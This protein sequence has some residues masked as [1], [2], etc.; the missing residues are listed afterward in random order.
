MRV[1]YLLHRFRKDIRKRRGKLAAGTGFAV[2]YGLARVAEPWPLKV[3]FDQVLFHKH[4]SGFWFAPFQMFGTSS[5]ALL[6]A[7]AVLLAIAGLVRG[8]AY[9]YEDFLISS[10][11]QEIVYGI[12]ARLYRHL[13]LLSMSF[14]ARRRAGDTLVRLSTDIIVLRD[15][16]IDTVVN[17]GSSVILIVMMGTVMMI[18]DPVLTVVSM[19]VVPLIILLTAVYGGALR[20]TAK[21]QRKREGQVASVMHEALSAID[22]VQLHGASGREQERFQDANRRSLKHGV[23]STRVEARMNRGVELALAGGTVVVMWVG[24]LRALSGAITP[25][26]LIVFISYVRGAYRPLRRASKT[27]QRAG[28]AIAAGERIVEI[29]DERPDIA[30]APDARPAPPLEGRVGFE[31]VSFAYFED[32]PVLSDVSFEIQPGSKVAIVGTTGSGKSTLVSL[33]PRLIDPQTGR[34]TLD[35]HDVRE[36][37]LESVRDQISLV[38][39]EA[40]LFG[41]SV[42][43]NIRYGFPT[44]TDEEVRAAASAAG[45]D[46]FVAGLPDGFDTTISERG[47][48]LSGGERQRLSI[49]RAFVR[50]SPI[51]ILDEPTTGLDVT[52]Q[53]GIFDALEKLMSDTTTLL[54]T[55]DMRLVR[56]ADEI[57]VLDAGRIVD[58]GTHAELLAS[59]QYFQAL[60]REFDDPDRGTPEP[61]PP[62]PGASAP[63]ASASQSRVLF[64]SHNGVGVGHLQRQLDLATAY[65]RRHPEDGV[66]LATGS[67]AAAMFEF[68]H[69]V[70]YLKLPSISMV[71]RYRNWEP[72]DLPIPRD[73]VI[74]MRSQLLEQ[75]VRSYSPNLLVADFMPAGPYGELLP[76]LEELERQGGV[77]V[78]GFRDVIDEP[79]FVRELWESTGIYETLRRHYT[80]ICCYGDPKMVNFADAYGLDD[81]L[82]ARLRYCGYLGRDSQRTTD[83]P[84]YERPFVLGSGGGGVDGA[85]VLE[86]FIAAAAKLRPE[87]GGT[88]LMVT[89]PLM[90]AADQAR[91]AGLAETAGVTVR[92]VVP[93][94]RAHSALADCVVSMAGYNTVC[95]VLSYRRPAVLIPRP[96]PSQEQTL[97]ARRLEEWGVAEVIPPHDAN[98][99]RVAGAIR[100]AL[101]GPPPPAAPISLDGLASAAA[102]FDTAL[103]RVTTSH[104]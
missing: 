61:S 67:H 88:W 33:V 103:E 102:V 2:I 30:D 78:A 69:G 74:E 84:L 98:P 27:V 45:L 86:A 64:Y 48:S 44:A 39:Q 65:K 91:L 83:V 20:T 24:T 49:A 26:D 59:S 29:L 57:V 72:R 100:N 81:V 104:H 79:S 36:L 13:H 70:D 89:G 101:E 99:D 62:G 10:A 87:L 92:R 77:A 25:G 32:H 53:R 80:A 19:L 31:G 93:E 68:P 51:L 43:E 14:Y 71:D 4:A 42:A 12:R 9:Y 55:H 58:R 11:A 56:E 15:I 96:E 35:G 1:R 40:I 46:A 21:K 5:H 16:L 6:A 63:G 66:L 82:A 60:A 37:T 95:D 34:V 94:L 23:R 38:K 97:R 17:L 50:R 76:A 3:V 54:I 75:T 47:M 41:L 22:I 85:P 52:T 8:I 18:I 7:A 90:A 73:E 28:K